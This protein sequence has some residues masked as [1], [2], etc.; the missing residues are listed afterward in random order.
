[1]CGTPVSTIVTAS[2]HLRVL[3]PFPFEFLDLLSEAMEYQSIFCHFFIRWLYFP[4][5]E[6]TS[7]DGVSL[8]MQVL[9]HTVTGDLKINFSFEESGHRAYAAML[10]VY[11][12]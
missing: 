3:P 4:Y 6:C 9:I 2:P 11:Y 1:M 5:N 7:I 8:A 12:S 10:K